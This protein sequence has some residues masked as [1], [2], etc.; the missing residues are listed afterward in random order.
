MDI[1]RHNREAWNEQVR[2]QNQW[3]IPV[4]PEEVARAREGD[5][6]VVLTPTRPVPI[7][8]FGELD[9][10]RVLCL[11][12]GGGQQGPILAAAGA[13]VTVYDNSP[14]QLAQDRMVADRDGLELET[15]EGDM[16]DLS[17]FEDGVFDLLFHPCSNSFVPDI[18][19]VWRE[20]HRVLRTGGTMLA[21][22]VNPVLFVFD[23][24]EMKRGN[25]KV[26]HRIPYSDL[27]DITDEE[28]QDLID[29]S[30]PLCFGHTLEDQIGGQTEAGFS[31]VGFFEDKWTDDKDHASISEFLPVFIATRSVASSPIKQ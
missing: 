11:A 13:R 30:E 4:T 23:Y 1:R 5:F 7:D 21:G 12:S 28:R 27:K 24:E 10:A 3:T 16:R 19:P 9:G 26:R 2:K 20:S 8:W 15:V 6:S 25:L 31:I 18:R 14:E 22:F 17:C 29:Q